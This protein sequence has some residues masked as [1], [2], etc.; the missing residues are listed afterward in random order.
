MNFKTHRRQ[1][2]KSAVVAGTGVVIAN[3]QTASS[4]TNSAGYASGSFN[5]EDLKKQKD[6]RSSGMDG[7]G[8]SFAEL[9]RPLR[10]IAFGG[11]PDDCELKVGGCGAMWAA[12]GHQVLFVSVTNGDMGH[13]KTV[14]APLA[15]RRKAEVQQ[16]A[17][18]LGTNVHVIDEI[19][20]TTLQ[21]TLENRLRLIRL[22]REWKADVVI[23][24]RPYDYQADHRY[25]GVLMQDTAFMAAVPG[26]LPE[27]PAI[28][29][30]VYLYMFDTFT[31]PIPFCADI[32]VSIESVIEKKVAALDVMESQFYEGGCMANA[33]TVPA[34]PEGQKK[35]HELIRDYLRARSAQMANVHRDALVKWY[36]K[37]KG[38]TISYAE[39]FEICEYGRKITDSDIRVLFPFFD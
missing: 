37:D 19:G 25:T 15:A 20:D 32:A 2:L 27:I 17:K 1:F 9:D 5:N 3:G 28:P 29:N 16:A 26:V 39:C 18:I 31:R 12:L 36:G 21:P 33:H 34:Q 10:I 35:R 8:K 11:H 13:W 30:P 6:F 14:G 24:H 22:I 23:G 4:Q 7:T 38:E